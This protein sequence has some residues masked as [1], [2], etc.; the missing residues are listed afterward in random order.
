MTELVE[1][2]ALGAIT[3]TDKECPFE[4]T[5]PHIEVSN[6]FKGKG[7]TLGTRMSARKSTHI[8]SNP[9]LAKGKNC[10]LLVERYRGL[11]EDLPRVLDPR[12]RE[13]SEKV[14]HV[15]FTF[16]ERTLVAK[17]A[18]V[19]EDQYHYQRT[20]PLTYP[21]TCAAHHLIPAQDSLKD[22]DI[23]AWMCD[24]KPQEFLNNGSLVTTSPGAV[25]S[26]VGYDVNGH[27][28]GI[29]L[30]GS[31]AVNE[32][33][34]G[35]WSPARDGDSEEPKFIPQHAVPLDEFGK[36]FRDAVASGK[37]S[38]DDR[39][40]L[41]GNVWYDGSGTSASAAY[42]LASVR[43]CKAQF[44]DSHVEYN[45]FVSKKL[46][47]ISASYIHWRREQETPQGCDKCRKV[48]E[49]AGVDAKLGPPPFGIV[50]RLN[51]LSRKLGSYLQ[52]TTWA[53]GIYTSEYG[54]QYID[55]LQVEDWKQRMPQSD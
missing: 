47:E 28:N 16:N 17:G 45:K 40:L 37:K 6:D 48:K 14:T 42:V 44:H 36:A 50:A 15:T 25:W 18:S 11:Y 49:E 43:R 38:L 26:N 33:G 23:L 31:Y 53:P 29:Y 41:N 39:P 34:S 30:P 54:R 24:N 9:R 21:V 52:G 7:K 22:N 32:S 35:H 3:E 8:Y 51:A 19:W 13:G 12:L 4:H 55:F 1:P 46:L 27:E 10:Q 2:V 20:P 5:F